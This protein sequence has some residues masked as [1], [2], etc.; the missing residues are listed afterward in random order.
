MGNI[1][2]EEEKTMCKKYE[3]FVRSKLMSNRKILS[4]RNLDFISLEQ[5]EN[6]GSRS[7][8]FQTHL[9]CF[10]ERELQLHNSSN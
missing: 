9:P 8:L 5:S 7:R 6:L 2:M 4:M 3:V 10:R 1:W